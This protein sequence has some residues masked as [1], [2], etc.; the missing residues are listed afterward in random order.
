MPH[1]AFAALPAYGH[2]FPLVP[3]ALAT[4]ARGAR[5]TFATGG[6]LLGRLPVPTE[7]GTDAASVGDLVGATMSRF[8]AATEDM[9]TRWVPAFFGVVHAEASLEPLRRL[10]SHDRPDLVVYETTHSAARVVADDLGIA[11]VMCGIGHI[12]PMM[13]SLSEVTRRHLEDPSV[14]PWAPL[15]VAPPLDTYLDPMPAALQQGDASSIRTRRPL[16]SVAW[17]E[18]QPDFVAPWGDSRRPRIYVT[19]GTV[20]SGGG[21]G[22]EDNPIV[23]LVREAAQVGNVLVAVG[24]AGDPGA[25][26]DPSRR[27]H[28]ARM[29]PQ[30][31]VLRQADLVVHHGGSGT[32]LAAAA[33]GVPQ[34]VVPQGADQF[35]NSAAV[36]SA[37]IGLAFPGER[38]PGAVVDA[39]TRL[40]DDD[41]YRAAARTVAADIAAMPDPDDV[42]AELVTDAD[43]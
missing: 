14:P 40:R 5:V 35:L 27:I 7:R 12:L 10:W 34:I 18:P 2:V 8:P 15:D 13:T 37:R 29:V 24:P 41:T 38:P 31:T 30:A 36:A 9:A 43:R 21:W 20:F 11:S 19:L 4:Q 22:S 28:A 32:T 6:E 33:A 3:L 39:L 26:H 1:I 42:A 16:R 17:E 25:V 23:G